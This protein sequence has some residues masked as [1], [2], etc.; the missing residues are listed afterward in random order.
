MWQARRVLV[1]LVAG[2][3]LAAAREAP[4]ASQVVL[5]LDPAASSITPAQGAPQS[6][7]GSLTLELGELPVVGGATTLELL[8]VSVTASGGLGITLDPDSL[9]PGSFV[10]H[11]DGRFE[12]ASALFLRLG[13]DGSFLDLAIPDLVGELTF[14]ENGGEV[15]RLVTEFALDGGGAAGILDVAVVA[16]PEP[17]A[18]LLLGAGLVALGRAAL[19]T[20]SSPRRRG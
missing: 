17:R 10:L 9:S 4:A 19:R 2:L 3:L 15:R 6:L 5:T 18:V 7:S 16:V 14:S 13:Q 11:A 12:A 8:D 20:R 1:W